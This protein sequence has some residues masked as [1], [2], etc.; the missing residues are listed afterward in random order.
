MLDL[1]FKKYAW[2]ANLALLFAAAWLC[3]RTVNTVVAAL[4]R[5]RPAVDLSSVPS[6]PPRPAAP[7]RLDQD[8]LFA[9]I[10]QKPPPPPAAGDGPSAR[11]QT[12]QNCADRDAPPVKSGLRAQLVAGVVSSHPG[13]SIA[14]ILDLSS[15]EIRVYGV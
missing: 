3:A 5:A 6:G 2:T 1:F 12:P 15:R 13:S 9:L 11:P 4:I 14:S 10:G 7:A 8:R